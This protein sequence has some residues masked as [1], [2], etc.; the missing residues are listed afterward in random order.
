MGRADHAAIEVVGQPPPRRFASG[1]RADAKL[2]VAAREDVA[3]PRSIVGAVRWYAACTPEDDPMRNLVLLPLLCIG[4][5]IAVASACSR[6]G[7]ASDVPVH[8]DANDEPIA[9]GGAPE[10]A[11]PVD[12]SVPDAPSSVYLQSVLDRLGAEC[13]T[14]SPGTRCGLAVTDLTTRET[15]LFQG[16]K[17]FVSASSPKAVWVAAALA[18]R[19]IA[20]VEPEASEIFVHSDDYASGRV[21]LLLSPGDPV[22]AANRI[23]TFMWNDVGM[24][25]SAFCTWAYGLKAINCPHALGEDNYFTARD[26]LTFLVKLNDR[27][28]LSPEATMA[29]LKWMTWSPRTGW[30]G[31][32]GS[33]LPASVRATIHHKAGWLAPEVFAGYS[34][35][36]E[37]GIV[38]LGGGG[39]YA[40]ATLM[41]G[42]TNYYGRQGPMMEYA[43]CVIFHAVTRDVSDP[44]VECRHP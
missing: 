13:A 3:V 5:L 1:S 10:A 38:D 18:S 23:N 19:G 42:G 31:W 17:K 8:E 30:G 7:S 12:A 21:V 34:V 29:L 40:M 16:T 37:I 2:H 14:Y 15:A 44:F 43:S 33:Q 39:A 28:L 9:D 24:S 6:D 22:A 25:D 36:H 35:T 27:S 4:S 26:A 11:G 41:S 32:I 20:A